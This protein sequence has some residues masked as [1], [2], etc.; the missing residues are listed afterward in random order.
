MSSDSTTEVRWPLLKERAQFVESPPRPAAAQRRSPRST[1]LLTGLAFLCGGLV[2]AAVFSIGW[3]HQAQ[4][5]TAARSA[6][7][8][9]TARAHHLA[10][11]L[12][13]ARETAANERASAARA[14]ASL[15]ATTRSATALATEAAA[16]RRSADGISSG[17]T[18]VGATTVRVTRELQ[19]LLDY[20]TTTPAAQIDSGYIASQAGYLNRQL[21]ALQAAGGDVAKSATSFETAMRKLT[22]DAAAL[23]R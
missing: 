17:A 3:R 19:T 23:G 9:A 12:A 20:L 1:W 5:D 10:A 11:E 8:A 14:A 18:G 16:S 4:R 6:L 2:S 13:A 15:R 22:R 21:S 7:A